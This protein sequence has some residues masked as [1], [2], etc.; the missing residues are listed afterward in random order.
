MKG[1]LQLGIQEGKLI[2]EKADSE[3]GDY[4]YKYILYSEDKNKCYE[5]QW[6]GRSDEN[7][8]TCPINYRQID[9]QTGKEI[10]KK[11]LFRV[12]RYQ[13]VEENLFFNNVHDFEIKI[14]D[15]F[16]KYI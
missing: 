5:G 15:N 10:Y 13:S 7:N 6:Y 4:S 9:L 11:K 3:Y 16:K 2:V 14:E 8:I 1:K 12:S